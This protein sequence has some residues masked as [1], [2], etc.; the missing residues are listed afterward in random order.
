MDVGVVVSDVVWIVCGVDV[1][2]MCV[3][4]V[5]ACQ[6][7]FYSMPVFRMLYFCFDFFFFLR[8]TCSPE[9]RFAKELKIQIV[10]PYTADTYMQVSWDVC[11]C[12]VCCV[13]QLLVCDRVLN[14]AVTQRRWQ[15]TSS[16]NELF[17]SFFTFVTFFALG[18]LFDSRESVDKVAQALY[19]ESNR[20]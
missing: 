6:L 7:C 18:T 19:I 3:C 11:E 1:H 16:N 2:W 4:F 20:E 14:V 8:G 17:F 5:C 12:L 10:D 15:S 13:F 9:E